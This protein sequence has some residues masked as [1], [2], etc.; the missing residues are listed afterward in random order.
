[1]DSIPQADENPEETALWETL[2]RADEVVGQA[3]EDPEI[4]RE[5]EKEKDESPEA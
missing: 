3:E 4:T 5:W 1:M 2:K